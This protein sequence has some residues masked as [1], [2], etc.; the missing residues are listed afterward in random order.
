MRR[1][2]R[3]LIPALAA[4]GLLGCN[5]N[6]GGGGGDVPPEGILRC[7]DPLTAENGATVAVDSSFNC[8]GCDVENADAIVDDDAATSGTVSVP[9]ALLGGSLSVTVGTAPGATQPAPASPGFV[10]NSPQTSLL[11]ANLAQVLSVST[12]LGGEVQEENVAVSLLDLDLLSLVDLGLGGSTDGAYAL[13]VE[14]TQTPFDALQ[15]TLFSL[16]G[17]N[18]QLDVGGACANFVLEEG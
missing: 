1:V 2:N 16:V 3:I 6:T 11:G 15:L 4:T 17:A 9:L 7:V 14:D 10:L 5:A 12:L 8:I 13:L 18:L